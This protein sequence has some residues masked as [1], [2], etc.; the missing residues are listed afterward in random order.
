MQA[1]TRRD[2]HARRLTLRVG[3]P[4]TVRS[5]PGRIGR[6]D[7]I[8]ASSYSSLRLERAILLALVAGEAQTGWRLERQR[9][10]RTAGAVKPVPSRHMRMLPSWNGRA[11]KPGRERGFDSRHP[12]QWRGPTPHRAAHT[13][14]NGCSNRFFNELA[15]RK[16]GDVVWR[17]GKTRSPHPARQP[18]NGE[19]DRSAKR[20][21]MAGNM[22]EEA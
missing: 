13:L 15:P 1:T 9:R 3:Y 5:L 10:E 12:H 21:R 20:R 2:L 22:K 19:K 6:A 14:K 4:V 18:R 16:D 8:T 17:R 11:G 7:H